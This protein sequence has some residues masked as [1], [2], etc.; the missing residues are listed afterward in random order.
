M[1]QDINVVGS[2]PEFTQD[3]AS[4]TGAEELKKTTGDEP[5]VEETAT[6]EIPAEKPAD[7]T[8]IPVGEDTTEPQPVVQA[9]V[10]PDPALKGLQEERVKLIKEIAELRGQKR[11]IKKQELATVDHQID[12]LKDLNPDDIKVIDRVMR[13]KGYMT[14]EEKNQMS[15]KAVEQDELG[16]FL[17][18]YPEYKPENDPGDVKWTQLQN[19][20]G[21]YKLPSDARQIGTIL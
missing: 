6:P 2:I 8:E 16:K 5:V 13:A 21:L 18:K 15:Y 7:G 19:E 20:L 12:E 4:E 10:Q 17:N 9:P 3:S 1:A 14:K 11:E